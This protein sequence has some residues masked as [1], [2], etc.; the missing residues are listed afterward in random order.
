MELIR[1]TSYKCSFLLACMYTEFPQNPTAFNLPEE[2]ACHDL[3]PP[4]EDRKKQDQ[5]MVA[6]LG[7]VAWELEDSI[8]KDMA[9]TAGH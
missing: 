8:R 5:A 3:T 1:V 7:S 9:K 6:D 2:A 4:Q